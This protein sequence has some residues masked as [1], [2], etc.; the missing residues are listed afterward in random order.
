METTKIMVQG[1]GHDIRQAS[2]QRFQTMNLSAN[3]QTDDDNTGARL[4]SCAQTLVEWL[5]REG[6][7]KGKS[8]VELGCG[9]GAVS[10]ACSVLGGRVVATDGNPDTVALARQNFRDCRVYRWG[11]DFGEK[12][13]V[14]V[15]AELFYYNTPLEALVASIDH[16]LKDEGVAVLCHRYREATLCGRFIDACNKRGLTCLDDGTTTDVRLHVVGRHLVPTEKLQNLIDDYE[17]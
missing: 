9:T 4:W 5:E 2:A 7:V 10:V 6:T 17:E 15:G 1:R 3:Q 13:D 8:V 11:D 14:V 12:F 16:L